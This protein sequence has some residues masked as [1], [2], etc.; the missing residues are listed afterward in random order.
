MPFNAD[1]S[2]T[3][4]DVATPHVLVTT[5]AYRGQLRMGGAINVPAGQV[6]RAQVIG[7]TNA[8]V[9]PTAAGPGA[10]VWIEHAT[11]KEAD[12]L[13]TA[14]VQ[15]GVAAMAKKKAAIAAYRAAE[16]KKPKPPTLEQRVAALEAKA[17][18][19]TKQGP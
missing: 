3:G 18:I 8:L 13:T 9:E 17:L 19:A 1:G 15:A 11:A 2:Y 5:K 4:T 6:L 14:E 16:A 10:A 7:T 12:V